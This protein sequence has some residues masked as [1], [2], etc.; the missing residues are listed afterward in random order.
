MAVGLVIAVPGG[1]QQ[2]YDAV[3]EALDLTEQKPEGLLLHIAGPVEDGWRIIDVWESRESFDE[4]SEKRLGEAAKKL[5]VQ[6]GEAKQFAIDH[7]RQYATRQDDSQPV[8]F[9]FE[10]AG[11]TKDQY[12]AVLERLALPENAM[13]EG[14]LFHLAGPVEGGWRVIDVWES[15]EAFDRFFSEQLERQLSAVGLTAARPQEF[16]VHNLVQYTNIVPFPGM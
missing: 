12:E 13:P 5:G 11:V 9:W 7:M 14:G 3:F 1:T 6:L 8:G 4:F 15:R 10:L 2:R 16:G